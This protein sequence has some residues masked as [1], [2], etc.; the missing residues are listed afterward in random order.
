MEL[1]WTLLTIGNRSSLGIPAGIS[2]KMLHSLI[3][4]T[5]NPDEINQTLGISFLIWIGIV[6][7]FLT[8]LVV[9]KALGQGHLNRV[10]KR[11]GAEDA[12]LRA[13]GAFVPVWKAKLY[14][15]LASSTVRT[16]RWRPRLLRVRLI[17]VDFQRLIITTP[18]AQKSQSSFHP[19]A[20]MPSV[21]RLP[22]SCL[23]P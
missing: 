22:F 3:K 17:N 1:G 15:A 10:I 19:A 7:V 13:P 9:W 21:R 23:S 5:G 18:D 20:Y 8:P 2:R 14:A 16:K 4:K 12:R 11:W 6:L